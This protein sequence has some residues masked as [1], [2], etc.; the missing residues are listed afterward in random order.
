VAAELKNA[1]QGAS[2]APVSP[3]KAEALK[4]EGTA[5]LTPGEV[6]GSGTRILL[7]AQK[8]G[9]QNGVF[10]ITKNEAFAAEGNFGGLGKFAVGSG[11]TLV[12][13]SDTD[14]EAETHKGMIVP[15]EDASGAAGT[16]ILTSEDPINPGVTSQSFQAMTATPAGPAGGG[17]SG[18]YPNPTIGNPTEWV[19]PALE[20][21][22]S[23]YETGYARVAYRKDGLGYV[24]LKGTLK[25]GTAVAGT[26]LFALPAGFRPLANQMFPCVAGTG[27]AMRVNVLAGG[28]LRLGVGIDNSYLDLSGITF[29]AEA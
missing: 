2:S 17:L 9:S 12:R 14:T 8:T 29:K 16:W 27:A 24:H 22:W 7:T 10:D 3:T 21:S 26:D 5:P 15:D 25:G 18:F 20:N 13:S 28:Q 6:Y 23:V 11:W 4:L 19:E 1:I